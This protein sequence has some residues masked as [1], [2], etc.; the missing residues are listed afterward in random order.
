VKIITI[1]KFDEI[2]KTKYQSYAVDSIS[3]NCQVGID[4]RIETWLTENAAKQITARC[5][6][7]RAV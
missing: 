6:T 7:V 4:E 1:Y 3:S 5:V 2:R